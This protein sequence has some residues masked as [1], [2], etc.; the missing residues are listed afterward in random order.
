MTAPRVAPD[1]TQTAAQLLRSARIIARLTQQELAAAAGTSQAAISAYEASKRQ[2]SV[3][4][5]AHLLEHCGQ[6]LTTTPR[7][8]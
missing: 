1:H 4:A 8:T 3:A 2:P 5:L 7:S 6:Q